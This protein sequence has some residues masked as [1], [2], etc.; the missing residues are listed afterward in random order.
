MIH[1]WLPVLL[2]LVLSVSAS[3]GM[4]AIIWWGFRQRRRAAVRFAG[5]EPALLRS[6]SNL[7]AAGAI[8]RLKAALLAGVAALLVISIARPQL[9]ERHTIL[10][11]QGSDVVVALDVSRSMGVSDV[12]PSR[13][14]AAKRAATALLDH[15]SGDRGA[16]VVF[17]GSASVRFPL[18]TDLAAADQVING[19]TIK[20]SGVQAGTGIASALVAAHDVFTGDKTRGKVIVLISDGEDLSGNDLAAAGDAAN[21]GVIL[22]TV[23]VGTTGGGPVFTSDPGRPQPVIDPSTGRQAI[24]HRDDGHLQQLAAAGHGTAYDGNSTDFAF[25]LS[26]AIDRLQK[27]QFESGEVTIP[28]ERFQIPLAIALALLILDSLIPESSRAIKPEAFKRRAAAQR[29]P[30]ESA[31]AQPLSL[32]GDSLGVRTVTPVGSGKKAEE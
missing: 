15:L 17:A 23:G 4:A 26:G 13:L 29:A 6:G 16:L 27:T 21:A 10:P 18:T 28:L 2:V 9:G 32:F 11:R 24:S 30:A 20:D 1:F 5:G 19:V 22:E 31:Q 3:G 14:D 7:S 12:T 25:D 8:W